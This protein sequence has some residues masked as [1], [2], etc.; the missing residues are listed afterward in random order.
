MNEATEPP[1]VPGYQAGT[2]TVDP[3]NSS[4]EFAIRQL[5]TRARGR[6]TRYEIAGVAA[7]AFSDSSVSATIELASIDTGNPKRDQHLRGPGILKVEKYPT[8]HYQSTGI[9][10]T[11]DSLILDGELELHGITRPV[12]LTIVVS[13]YS[14]DR[15]GNWRASMSAT[16]QIRRRDFGITI[17]M[18]AAGVIVADKISIS[19][20]LEAVHQKR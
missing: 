16:G 15:F 8:M 4:I 17:A 20:Q 2:W 11:T 13:T 3:Q 7:E 6:F 10:R 12:P 19:L 1:A 9:R 14:T 5:A 18:A